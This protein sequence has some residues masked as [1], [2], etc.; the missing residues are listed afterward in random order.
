[1]IPLLLAL[2]AP[3]R[4]LPEPSPVRLDF[5][6]EDGAV[7]DGFVPATAHRIADP[8]A[9]WREPP[10]RTRDL[11]WPEP[12]SQDFA[13][14]GSLHLDLPPGRYTVAGLLEDAWPDTVPPRPGTATGLRI[15]EVL[16]DRRVFPEGEA[17]FASPFHAAAPFPRFGPEDTPWERQVRHRA[18]WRLAE[19]TVGTDGLVVAAE[20]APLHA[21]VVTPRDRAT[22]EV[23]LAL[24]DRRRRD[25]F[26]RWFPPHPDD[27]LP[28]ATEGLQGV[29]VLSWNR[30]PAERLPAGAPRIDVALAPGQRRSIPLAVHG[31][32]APLEVRLDG[33]EG[34]RA[35]LFEVTW[36]DAA[37]WR[38]LR[39]Q[40]HLLRPLGEDRT[41]RAGQGLLPLL[42]LGLTPAADA[43]PGLHEGT[44]VLSR[45]DLRLEV[46]LTV[47]VRDLHL[48]PAPVPF[49][50]WADL[51]ATAAQIYGPQDPRT[52]ALWAE[53]VRL[54]RE[55]GASVLALRGDSFPVLWPRTADQLDAER[56]AW[57]VETWR[58]AGGGD[59]VWVA[60]SGGLQPM[61]A[62]PG[63]P[64]L[65]DRFRERARRALEL[66]VEHDVSLYVADEWVSHSGPGVRDR[67]AR[68]LDEIRALDATGRASITV[69]AP[70]PV[71]WEVAAPRVDRLLTN[72]VPV[73]DPAHF[74]ALRAQGTEAWAYNY[75]TGRDAAG[76][77][78]WAVEADG[79]LI[80]HWNDTRGTPYDSTA[81][82]QWHH[83]VLAPDG[84]T[85]WPT[86]RAE[87]LGHG[88]SD[89]RHYATLAA[90]VRELG[91]RRRR[92]IREGVRHACRL[93]RIAHAGV[94]GRTPDDLYDLYPAE[95]AALQDLQDEIG[96]TAERLA[97]FSKRQ[98]ARAE[99]ETVP[100]LSG[101]FPDRCREEGPPTDV[102]TFQ[103]ASPPPEPAEPGDGEG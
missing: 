89:Q 37:D 85:V 100:P 60:A 18:S 59:V 26:L 68:Y 5:G 16:H 103:T 36:L 22:L 32:D 71:G 39:P 92:R 86:R 31:S 70:H 90:L 40:P 83:S 17:F 13:E 14:D 93:L 84:R 87:V 97:R 63:G 54:M 35:E 30:V 44:L 72:R 46:P 77:A 43:P 67:Y 62:P 102:P 20:G 58:A 61:T 9:T 82:F 11:R 24:M 42:A 33:L 75:G 66:A 50:W 19:V 79:I 96:D 41:L 74:D 56:L 51:R 73:L 48:E 21:L 91:D 10:R 6:D 94:I 65:D 69:A 4:E 34:I 88:V 99:G 57:G 76:R 23:E 98:R 38:Q 28:R 15:G 53:D 2:L 8:R 1:M 45:D 3:A 25:T 47:R 27:D 52:Q 81:R 55:R 64:I 95:D 12:L 80:W 49:G 29:Q 7:M 78:P 101:F